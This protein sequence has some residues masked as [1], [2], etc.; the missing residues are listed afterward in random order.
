MALL[1]EIRLY[2]NSGLGL[3]LVKNIVEAHKG[4]LQFV[5]MN[6]G[7]RVIISFKE[8]DKA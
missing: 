3:Y 1:T 5:N 7:L 6:P 4:E 2:V 8:E